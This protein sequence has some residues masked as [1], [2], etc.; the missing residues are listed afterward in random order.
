VIIRI[1]GRTAGWNYMDLFSF[2][3]SVGQT[4]QHIIAEYVNAVNICPQAQISYLVR[5]LRAAYFDIYLFL[6]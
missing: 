6:P 1:N 3:A 5:T 4:E 2:I